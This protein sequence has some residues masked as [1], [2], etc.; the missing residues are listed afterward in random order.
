MPMLFGWEGKGGEGGWGEGVFGFEGGY[1]LEPKMVTKNHRKV[2]RFTN[3]IFHATNRYGHITL[4]STQQQD[5]K[6][7]TSVI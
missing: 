4:P 7:E 1:Y 3:K 6:K 2:G 5:H